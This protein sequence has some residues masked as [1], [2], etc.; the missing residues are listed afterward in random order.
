MFFKVGVLF[1]SSLSLPAYTEMHGVAPPSGSLEQNKKKNVTRVCTCEDFVA[2]KVRLEFLSLASVAAL[3]HC[4]R[5]IG[6]HS[7][8]AGTLRLG[9]L[10]S[11]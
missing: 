1:F 9:V 10:P 4:S 11:H 7:N 6:I 5:H 2:R 8:S 3:A